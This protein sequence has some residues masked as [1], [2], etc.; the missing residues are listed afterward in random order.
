MKKFFLSVFFLAI[1]L[2]S[3]QAQLEV[4]AEQLEKSL[5]EHI[6]LD[7]D[8]PNSVGYLYIGDHQTQI[9]QGTFIYVKKALDAYKE[10]KPAFIILKLDTPGGQVFA[11][12]KISDALKEIDTQYDIP[13]V[14]FIDNWAISAGAMLAY[15]CRYIAIVKD[16]SMGAAQPVTQA[17]AAT[18]EKVNSAIRTDFANRAAFYDRNPLLAEAMVDADMILVVRDDEIVQLQKE[19]QI[20]EG[21]EVITNKGKLLTLN[22]SELVQFGVA[23]VRLE[24]EKLVPI[25]TEEKAEGIWPAEKELLFTHPFFKKIPQSKILAYKMD[26]KTKFF[27]ILGSPLVSSL[28]FLGLMLCVYIEF[29][30]PGFGV[31]VA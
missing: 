12:Q 16:A 22:A 18:S 28:L 25:T 6:H 3:L 24:P 19:D 7:P 27:S 1:C 26:W 20:I 30:T 31:A 29:N 8:G 5:A 17:G 13:V 9:S 15:S 4:S 23:D 2:C 11:A 10:S 21:E 14:A